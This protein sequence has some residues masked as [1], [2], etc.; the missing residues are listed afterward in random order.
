KKNRTRLFERFRD[1]SF[2][3]P[4]LY[5]GYGLADYDIRAALNHLESFGD[6]R[7]MSYIVGPNIN[8]IEARVWGRKK[9]TA[10]KSTFE[11]FLKELDSSS[12]RELRK[13]ASLYQ[14]D[15]TT[16]I[17]KKFVNTSISPTQSL[18]T[19]LDHEFTY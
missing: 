12:N 10:L 13:L 15:P 7:P 16:P 9:I 14:I 3:H 6:N 2:E 8:D 4:I 11:A 17:K 18:Q 5:I 19:F 1:L